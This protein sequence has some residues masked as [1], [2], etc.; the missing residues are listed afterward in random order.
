M[1]D[2]DRFSI[3]EMFVCTFRKAED[4]AYFAQI[5]KYPTRWCVVDMEQGIVIDIKM[6]LKYEYIETTSYLN[7]LNNSYKKIKGDKRAAYKPMQS[8]Y[9]DPEIY[10]KGKEIIEKLKNGYEFVDG[11]DLY[12][13]EEYLKYLEQEGK[14]TL[15]KEK[16]KTKKMSIKNIFNK[17]V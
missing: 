11:N 1:K 2:N 5:G 16:T 9:I 3:N 4:N 8:I 13:N 14:E 7:F 6:G 10:A 12:S 15:S 17:K